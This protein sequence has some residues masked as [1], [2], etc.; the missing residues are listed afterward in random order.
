MLSWVSNDS[1]KWREDKDGNVI[2]KPGDKNNHILDALG[3]ALEPEM[4]QNRMTVQL[5][6]HGI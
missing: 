4:A 2:A 6:K 5:F 1:Y 3:Y